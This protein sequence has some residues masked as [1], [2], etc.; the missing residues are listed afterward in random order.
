MIRCRYEGGHIVIANYNEFEYIRGV[1]AVIRRWVEETARQLEGGGEETQRNSEIICDSLIY[2][3]YFIML[4]EN[5]IASGES[6]V[7]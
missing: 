5:A 2:A 1:S 3:A 7:L 4:L 6:E